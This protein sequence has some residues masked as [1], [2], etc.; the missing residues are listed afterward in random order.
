LVFP[1]LGLNLLALVVGLVKFRRFANLHLYL[2][3]AASPLFFVFMVHT[4]LFG[5]YSVVLL[6]IAC[7][8]IIVA[9]TETIILLLVRDSVDEHIGSLLFHF[10]HEDHPLQRFAPKRPAN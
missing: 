4:F 10:L 9:Y 7:V 3:K 2:S 6:T 5:Q 8:W 1:A